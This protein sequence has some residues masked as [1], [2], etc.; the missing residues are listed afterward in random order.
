M[1]CQ[2]SALEWCSCLKVSV[3]TTLQLHTVGQVHGGGG[4]KQLTSPEE[5][6]LTPPGPRPPAS[7]VVLDLQLRGRRAVTLFTLLTT[8]SVA[9]RRSGLCYA[10]CHASCLRPVLV[11]L[12]CSALHRLW[13]LQTHISG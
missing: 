3:Q 2:A 11:V 12:P 9:T 4:T 1:W 5:L 7:S 10:S 8:L 13:N 6:M